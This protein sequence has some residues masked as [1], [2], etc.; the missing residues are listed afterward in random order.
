MIK[1]NVERSK[2]IQPPYYNL[3]DPQ[4]PVGLYKSMEVSYDYFIYVP[5]LGTKIVLD[6]YRQTIEK[7]IS[8]WGRWI[9]VD[10]DIEINIKLR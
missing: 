2:L 1:I 3:S 8:P 10:A 7:V 6:I 4:T 5:S 9:K